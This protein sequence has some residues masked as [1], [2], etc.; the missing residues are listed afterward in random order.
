MGDKGG[1]K[2]DQDKP[3]MDLIDSEAM[4][5]LAKVLTFGAKKYAED[6]WR[7][8]IKIRRLIGAGLRH[9]FAFLR[10]EDNDEETGLSHIAHA[11]CCCMFIIWTLKHRE[12]LDDRYKENKREANP[13]FNV[14]QR[15]GR[16][17]YTG[18]WVVKC[19]R[20]SFSRGFEYGLVPFTAADV[21][22]DDTA[23]LFEVGANLEAVE[24]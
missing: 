20:R 24:E 1:T 18:T 10:G 7:K 21:T 15:V 12:D 16:R 5:E 23:P 6:N 2:F 11:M 19:V 14:W 8:G 17:G 4:E 22:L 9:M 13:T 3:R